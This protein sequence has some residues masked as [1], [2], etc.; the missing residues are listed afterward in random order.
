MSLEKIE[1]IAYSGYREEESPRAFFLAGRRI[2]VV[3]IVEQ[4]IEET[5]D[6]RERQRC[7]RVKGSDWKSHVI[8]YDEGK[9]EWTHRIPD[10]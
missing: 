4:W 7:Y 3:K 1:V 9:K 6:C 10:L 2:E 8:C 5:A